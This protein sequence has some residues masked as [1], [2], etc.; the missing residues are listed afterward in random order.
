MATKKNKVKFGLKNCHYALVTLAD[1]GTA[2]FGTPVAMPGAV[3]LSLDA[4]GQIGAV[5]YE[6]KDH[7]VTSFKYLY[8]SIIGIY[9]KDEYV[10]V[11]GEKAEE[12]LR[13]KIYTETNSPEIVFY[14]VSSSKCYFTIDGQGSYYCLVEDVK[15]ARD[16]L[17]KYINGETVTR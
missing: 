14:R 2:T 4:E 17:F 16:N 1:D 11:E 10:P 3:S 9:L 15:E 13:V 7:D 6:G 5:K 8:Q 12:Y